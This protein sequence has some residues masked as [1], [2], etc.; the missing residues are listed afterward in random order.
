MPT[1]LI[2]YGY[3]FFFF[4]ND[5]KEPIHIHVEKDNAAAKFWITPY[6]H[7]T[8]SN[9]FNSVELNKIHK[10][11]EENSEIFKTKWNEYFNG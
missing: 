9:G 2:L 10:L 4:S 6:I 7:L 5:R 1:V 8:K 11:V 3:R